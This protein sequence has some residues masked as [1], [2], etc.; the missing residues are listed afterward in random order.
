MTSLAGMARSE[1]NRQ[2]L[3]SR[4]KPVMG[5]C[6]N[7]N[8]LSC[9]QRVTWKYSTEDNFIVKAYASIWCSNNEDLGSIYFKI[10]RPAL[11]V[12]FNA[13]TLKKIQQLV[14]E[15][16]THLVQFIYANA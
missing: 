9:P 1:I 12:Y 5:D 14:L 2:I 3:N 16:T 13:S 8:S 15:S 10:I 11:P 6:N 7:R 4:F